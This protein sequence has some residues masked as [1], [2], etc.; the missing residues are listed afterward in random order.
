MVD[1]PVF[2]DQDLNANRA[3]QAGIAVTV[4]ILDI[5]EEALE[6]A[7]NRVLNNKR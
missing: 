7:I 2:G 6:N 4:E 1:I 3:T 5:T